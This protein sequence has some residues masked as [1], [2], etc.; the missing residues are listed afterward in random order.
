MFLNSDI[1]NMVT[2]NTGV[3]GT[4]NAFVMDLDPSVD[5]GLNRGGIR[6]DRASFQGHGTTVVSY[7]GMK[8]ILAGQLQFYLTILLH[9]VAALTAKSFRRREGNFIVFEWAPFADIQPHFHEGTQ[10]NVLPWWIAIAIENPDIEEFALRAIPKSIGRATIAGLG[11]LTGFNPIPDFP[12]FELGGA[13]FFDKFIAFPLLEPTTPARKRTGGGV[14]RQPW[15]SYFTAKRLGLAGA[16]GLA[17][18][19]ADEHVI[20]GLF[21]FADIAGVDD[22]FPGIQPRVRL[23]AI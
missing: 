18:L 2:A 10:K 21:R 15:S 5:D 16:V 9:E 8:K 23:T 11:G 7:A 3:W 1:Y 20:P 19:I 22:R 14:D 13:Q 12:V 4:E 17:P 6:L